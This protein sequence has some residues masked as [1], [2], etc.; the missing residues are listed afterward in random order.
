MVNSF[1]T[2]IPNIPGKNYLHMIVN[3]H[4][5]L[6]LRVRFVVRLCNW[7]SLTQKGRWTYFLLLLRL[8]EKC[9]D[10]LLVVCDKR[11]A[12]KCQVRCER[13]ANME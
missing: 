13:K 1:Q 11:N 7:T 10:R 12:A 4:Y 6:A 5:T 8:Q 9:T 3:C 2:H